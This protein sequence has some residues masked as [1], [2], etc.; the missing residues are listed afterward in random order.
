MKKVLLA[1]LLLVMV[2][3]QFLSSP[4]PTSAAS[5]SVWANYGSGVYYSANGLSVSLSSTSGSVIVYT[6]NGTAPQARMVLYKTLIIT[7]GT[8]YS[9]PITVSGNKQIRAIALKDIFTP[10]SPQVSYSYEVYNP[11]ALANSAQSKFY[12][13]NYKNY[14]FT[15]KYTAANGSQGNFTMTYTGITPGT[16]NCTWYTFTRSKYNTGRDILFSSAG[17]LDGKNWYSKMYGNSLQMKYAG[18]T[19]LEDI[20]RAYGNRPIYNVVVTF[21]STSTNTAGHV[22]LIDAIING[23]LYFS[24]NTRPGTWVIKNSV[25]EFKSYYSNSGTILGAV[26]VR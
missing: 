8:K 2:V 16:I 15:A 25:S 17:G 20:I 21:N 22:M 6:T 18:S 7:N 1:S 11:T 13:F 10:V 3:M 4:T 12:S 5:I 26:I 24:D 19:A 9:G 14:P 23:K